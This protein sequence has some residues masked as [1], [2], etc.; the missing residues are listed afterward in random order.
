MQNV[1]NERAKSQRNY[2]VVF[3]I[4]AGIEQKVIHVLT[5]IRASIYTVTLE[6]I[7]KAV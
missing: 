4:A 7:V 3:Q 2:A 1:K 6:A 5:L